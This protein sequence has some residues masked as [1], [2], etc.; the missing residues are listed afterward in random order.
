M[1]IVKWYH[2]RSE[3]LKREEG[4]TGH[5]YLE[6]GPDGSL[7]TFNN[8][9]GRAIRI[10]NEGEI[11]IEGFND[12]RRQMDF[13]KTEHKVELLGPVISGEEDELHRGSQA[14]GTSAEKF[15]RHDKEE[16][17]Q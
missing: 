17:S 16:G 12:T 15:L 6:F 11:Y 1:S 5:I 13:S 7:R 4:N 14:I 9:S 10:G 2:S 8:E 3:R